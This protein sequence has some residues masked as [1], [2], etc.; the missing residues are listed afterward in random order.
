VASI[1]ALLA[2]SFVVKRELGFLMLFASA[3]G[4]AYH[5]TFMP[6]RLRAFFRYKNLKDIPSSRDLFVALAWGTVLTAI[7]HIIN[8]AAIEMPVTLATFCWIFILGFLRSLIFDLRD[9]EG[10]R[11]MGRETLITI[12]GERRARKALQVLIAV[13]FSGLLVFPAF[14]GSGG[15]TK[16]NTVKF[17][18]QIPVLLYIQAFVLVNPRIRQNRNALFNLLADGLF[19]LAGFGALLASAIAA[20]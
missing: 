18:F 5:M 20:K 15:Y 2:V 17:L 19:Y 10:D 13:C 3:L 1:A 12:I 14:L 16:Q 8:E 11:I 6:K 9:I 4:S 7:P